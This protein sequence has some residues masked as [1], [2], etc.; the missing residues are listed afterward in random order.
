LL[1]R[2]S[3]VTHLDAEVARSR[4][5]TRP[6]ALLIFDLD[7]LKTINDTQGH[8]AGDA[9]L[10]RVADALRATT[11]TGDNAFRIG[12]D[13]F[14]VLLPEANRREAEAAARRI[15]EELQL[16]ASFGVAVCEDG[17][18]AGPLLREADDAMY[19]MK[20]RRRAEALRM[21]GGEDLSAVV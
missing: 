15:A 5:Y 3:F 14:A 17:C 12:G 16:A 7:E 21:S 2:R 19:R 9:A 20:R 1:N 8:A 18:E 4:R 10:K 11:R 6:L 13:E